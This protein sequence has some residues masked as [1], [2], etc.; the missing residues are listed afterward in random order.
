MNAPVNDNAGARGRAIVELFCWLTE[1]KVPGDAVGVLAAI[2]LL[3]LSDEDV[4]EMCRR[5]RPRDVVAVPG[6]GSVS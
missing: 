2:E 3:G 1:D 5:I 4:E 6:L